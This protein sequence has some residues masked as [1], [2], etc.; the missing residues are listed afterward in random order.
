M[1]HLSVFKKL[2]VVLYFAR[3]IQIYLMTKAFK[4]NLMRQWAL[5]TELRMTLLCHPK[6]NPADRQKHPKTTGIDGPQTDDSSRQSLT[7]LMARTSKHAVF[8]NV[9][10]VSCP[11]RKVTI[12]QQ[13]SH[14]RSRKMPSRPHIRYSLNLQASSPFQYKRNISEYEDVFNVKDKGM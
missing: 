2:T 6:L 10:S 9:A 1:N 8:S 13:S 12:K 4:C 3:A 7:D 11:T 14:T 5:N